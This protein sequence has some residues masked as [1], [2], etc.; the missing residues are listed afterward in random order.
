[1]A[2]PPTWTL[3]G[4][5][6]LPHRLQL[7]ARMIDRESARHLSESA[8]LTLA[9]WRVLVYVG[10][11]A[12]ASAADICTAFDIDRAEVSRAVARLSSAGL[13]LRE[14]DDDNRKRLLLELTEEGLALYRRTRDARVDYF[15]AILADLQPK[16]R[17]LLDDLLLR[18]A[19]KVD[20]LRQG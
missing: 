3:F 7:L 20:L 8:G 5:H 18:V 10:T 12:R 16:E 19:S 9:E 14:Q 17:E 4:E 2:L 1:M 11:K 13:L 6:H 15:R